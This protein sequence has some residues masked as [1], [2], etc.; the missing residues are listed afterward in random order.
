MELIW[1]PK[2]EIPT[3]HWEHNPAISAD[4]LVKCGY[5]E[6]GNAIIG[7]TRYSHAC[8][9]WMKCYRATEPGIFDV[10]EWSDVKL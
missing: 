3:D 1:K 8:N 4:Y 2:T 9:C 5:N 6:D 10:Q 7:Y